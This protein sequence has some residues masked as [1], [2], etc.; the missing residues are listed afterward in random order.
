MSEVVR[1]GIQSIE[2]G[3]M[4]A[5][6]S[7][8]MSWWQDMRYGCCRRLSE[9]MPPLGNEFIMLWDSSLMAVVPCRVTMRT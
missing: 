1:A 2:R 7:L 4:E 9:H 5:A 3:Q 8:G 6:R